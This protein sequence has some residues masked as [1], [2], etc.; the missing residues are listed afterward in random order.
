MTTGD[1][2]NWQPIETA[3]KDGTEVV[4]WCSNRNTFTHRAKWKNN[5]WHEWAPGAFDQMDWF[6]L[7]SYEHPSHWFIITPP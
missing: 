2:M 6:R 5:M 7:E 3:P 1:T 4:L